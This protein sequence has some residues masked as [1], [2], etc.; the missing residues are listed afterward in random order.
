[1]PTKKPWDYAI[2]LKEDFVLRKGQ[3]YSLSRTEK[4]KVQ[5]FMES[6]LKKGYIRP[7]KSL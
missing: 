3:I 1:M 4:E 2:D 5:V 7:S 6:Q